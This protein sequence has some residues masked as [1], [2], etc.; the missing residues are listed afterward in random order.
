MTETKDIP[1]IKTYNDFINQLQEID[2][3]YKTQE[4]AEKAGAKVWENRL[5]NAKARMEE[6]AKVVQSL[7]NELKKLKKEE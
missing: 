5:K 1:K 4:D 6:E 3:L 7:E 2:S